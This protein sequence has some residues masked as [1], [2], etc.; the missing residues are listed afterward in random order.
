[1]AM[2]SSLSLS[3]LSELS[4]AASLLS[5]SLS[6]SLFGCMH[7]C[8]RFFSI[9]FFYTIALVESIDPLSPIFEES[10]HLWPPG[11]ANLTKSMLYNLPRQCQV[12]C[13]FPTVPN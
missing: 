9:K 10:N 12:C 13:F 8:S 5:L 11:I 7:I 1:M 4:I 6:L 3:I 2:A